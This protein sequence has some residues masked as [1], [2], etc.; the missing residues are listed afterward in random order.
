LSSANLGFRLVLQL[1]I[2]VPIVVVRQKRVRFPKGKKV[3]SGAEQAT[4]K[5]DGDEPLP[6]DL[7]E[8]RLAA[9][10]RARR[11]SQT[12]AF[13]DDVDVDL[14]HISKV[15]VRYQ[16]WFSS[17]LLFL[18]IW[19]ATLLFEHLLKWGFQTLNVGRLCV[20]GAGREFPA[21]GEKLIITNHFNI[22]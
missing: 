3:K 17:A 1:L 2:F 7:S 22:Q 6:Q 16:V 11:R 18:Q 13:A 5:D 19:F 21:H 4:F 12:G 10:E 20:T 15:E 14:A 9:K 8:P